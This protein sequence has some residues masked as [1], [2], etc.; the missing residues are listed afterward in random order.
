MSYDYLASPYSHADP[1]VMENRYVMAMKCVAYYLERGIYV[2]SPIVACHE[3]A[4]RFTLPREVNFWLNYNYAMLGRA[5]QLI[6]LTLHGWEDSTG[7]QLESNFAR[8]NGIPISFIHPCVLERK[9]ITWS[10]PITPSE[11]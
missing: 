6:I 3:M 11:L 10:V 5:R 9:D 7:I 4:K 8:D 2:H 1:Q